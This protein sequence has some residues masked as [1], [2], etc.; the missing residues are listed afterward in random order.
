MADET[1]IEMEPDENDAEP[2]NFS[3]EIESVAGQA[4]KQKRDIIR[5]LLWRS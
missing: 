2:R 5:D 1:V 4:A 3:L